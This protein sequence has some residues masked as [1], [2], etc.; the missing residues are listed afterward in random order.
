MKYIVNTEKADVEATL[1][2]APEGI[3]MVDSIQSRHMF[4][5]LLIAPEGIEIRIK[6]ALLLSQI[7][8]INRTRRN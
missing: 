8:P 5:R 4:Y 7:L 3:E 6:H 1:L 2:I